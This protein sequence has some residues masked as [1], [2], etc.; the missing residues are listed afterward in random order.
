M[1]V[2]V[3][4]RRFAQGHLGYGW[5]VRA[6]RGWSGSCRTACP[7]GFPSTYRSR[8]WDW[9][10]AYLGKFTDMPRLAAQDGKDP[11]TGE[12]LTKEDLIDVIASGWTSTAGLGYRR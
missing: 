9:T 3:H 2:A 8:Q 10:G 1:R 7:R 4:G 6:R 5:A 12:G 11:I